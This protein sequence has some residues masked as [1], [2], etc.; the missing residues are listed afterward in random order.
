MVCA[1]LTYIWATLFFSSV[2]LQYDRV[3]FFFLRFIIL[4]FLHLDSVNFVKI[5]QLTYHLASTPT[6]W[7]PVFF[8]VL[9]AN[10]ESDNRA[11][12]AGGSVAHAFYH[13]PQ[14]CGKYVNSQATDKTSS[15]QTNKP[16]SFLWIQICI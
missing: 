2:L 14:P 4:I 9:T 12:D 13:L 6:C 1:M 10:H 3:F 11:L 15:K 8:I 7:P 5:F 16:N